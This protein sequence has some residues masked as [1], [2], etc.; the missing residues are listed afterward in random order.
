MTADDG[1][2]T[3]RVDVEGMALDE[4]V[5][6]VLAA[7]ASRDPEQVREALEYV[8]DDDDV[9]TRSALDETGAVLAQNVSEARE[10]A[11]EARLRLTS[12][13]EAAEPVTDLETVARRLDSYEEE[14]RAITEQADDLTE[15]HDALTGRFEDPESL[16]A[17]ADEFRAVFAE[18]HRIEARVYGLNEELSEFEADV[19]SP[20]VWINDVQQDLN[21]VEDALDAAAAAVEAL[22]AAEADVED[23]WDWADR[24]VDPPVVWYD[25]TLRVEH[26]GV[27]L[28]D[29]R[30]EMDD[31]QAWGE[32]KAEFE[33]WYAESVAEDLQAAAD[34][35]SELADRLDSLARPA[36][37][38]HF[39]DRLAEFESEPADLDAPVDW[40]E[41]Q[42]TL[43]A[44]RPESLDA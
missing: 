10:H 22:P 37:T 1:S 21:V 44:Y 3:E 20:E 35:R 29:L 27:L 15:R 2:V 14:V 43:D 39:G 38:D 34:R 19:T 30:A 26:V 28:T 12:A 8:T 32:R 11:S 24:D 13:R 4:A 33:T 41:M 6:A 23:D 42:A 40:V 9:V 31:L 7:D 25:A 36:W 18:A 16:Y 5:D 17:V